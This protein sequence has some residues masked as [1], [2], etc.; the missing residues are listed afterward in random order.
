LRADAQNAKGEAFNLKQYHEA[1]L[2]HGTLP[3][4]L[5]RDLVWSDLG[6]GK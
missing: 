1:V 5:L 6:L 3:L 2:S 4:N